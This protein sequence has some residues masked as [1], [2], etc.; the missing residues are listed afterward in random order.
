MIRCPG[1][2]TRIELLG[3]V[4]GLLGVLVSIEIAHMEPAS[5]VDGPVAKLGS[6]YSISRT[7]LGDHS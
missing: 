1:H 2:A 7:H 6:G 3:E 4:R 5:P